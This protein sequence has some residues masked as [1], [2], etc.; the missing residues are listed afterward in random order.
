MGYVT[1]PT[2]RAEE[3]KWTQ[4]ELKQPIYTNYYQK[5]EKFKEKLRRTKFKARNKF[6]NYIGFDGV[7]VEYYCSRRK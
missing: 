3:T 2:L 4:S 7:I 6:F 5:Q 1:V